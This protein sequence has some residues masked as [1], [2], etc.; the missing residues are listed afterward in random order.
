MTSSVIEICQL[1]IAGDIAAYSP[2]KKPKTTNKYI[3]CPIWYTYAALP[4]LLYCCVLSMNSD[5]D[6]EDEFG[7]EALWDDVATSP[8]N[9]KQIVVVS[10]PS[11]ADR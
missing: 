11:T 1:S 5:N 8:V 9:M 6:D 7:F 4:T 3:Q 10:R 2:Q